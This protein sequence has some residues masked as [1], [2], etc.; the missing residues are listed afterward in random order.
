MA[1]LVACCVVAVANA[2]VTIDK[3]KEGDGVN[4]PKVG[5]SIQVRSK[6]SCGGG[7]QGSCLAAPRPPGPAPATCSRTYIA[8]ICIRAILIAT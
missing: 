7:Q 8:P 2:G 5:K 3:I 6:A 4:F 1:A